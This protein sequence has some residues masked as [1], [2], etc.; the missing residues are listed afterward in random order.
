MVGL[1]SFVSSGELPL[2]LYTRQDTLQFAHPRLGKRFDLLIR[3]QDLPNQGLFPFDQA[4][5]R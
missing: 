2:R 4:L 5:V 1:S 3:R